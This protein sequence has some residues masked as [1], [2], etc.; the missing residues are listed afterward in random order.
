MIQMMN[1]LFNNQKKTRNDKKSMKRIMKY[2][3][4]Y[5]QTKTT[6]LHA[7]A[8]FPILS[9]RP[10]KFSVTCVSSLCRGPEA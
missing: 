2:D 9:H 3:K 4:K 7:A 8:C 10:T 1:S 5:T 6:T